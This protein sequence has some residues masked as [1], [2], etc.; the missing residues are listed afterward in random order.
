MYLE[1]DIKINGKHVRELDFDIEK[2]ISV[3]EGAAVH[4]PDG[5]VL[6]TTLAPKRGVKIGT[7]HLLDFF[8][9]LLE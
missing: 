4:L 1:G 6:E 8:A 3:A 5:N 2:R 9:A 7:G